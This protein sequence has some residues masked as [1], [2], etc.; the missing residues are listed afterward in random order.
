MV[1]GQNTVM[2]SAGFAAICCGVAA[3]GIGT[4]AE[5]SNYIICTVLLFVGV[6]LFVYPGT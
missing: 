4:A 6:L 5:I 2:K 3:A 1:P